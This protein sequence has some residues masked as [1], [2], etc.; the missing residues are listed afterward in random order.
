MATKHVVVLGH[1]PIGHSF[2][3]KLTESNAPFKISV[4]CE[5]PRPAYNRVML[6]QYFEDLDTNKHDQM[7][8]SYVTEEKLK[9]QDV[10]LIYGRATAV[11]RTARSVAYDAPGTGAKCSVQYDI[12]VMAT[13]SY[14]FV[15]PTPGMIIPEKRNLTWPDDPASRP[16]GVF[17]YRTIEDLES[18]SAAVKSGARKAAVIGGG[19]LGLEAAKAAY[20]LKLESHVLEMAPYLMPTQLNELGGTVLTDKIKDLGIQVHVGVQ[21]KEVVLGEDGKVTGIRILQ[22]GADEPIVLD[23]DMVIVSCGVRPRDELAKQCGLELGGRGGVKV[24]SSLRSSDENIYAIGEV[25]AIG[26]NLCY[27]L[28]APGV[29]QAGAL[30]KNLVDGPGSAEY[31]GSD[32]STKLKLLGCDVASF[33]RTLDFWF[34]RQFDGKDPGIKSLECKDEINGTYRRL[35]FTSDGSQLMGGILVGDA[36]DYSKLLQLSKKPD[37]AGNDPAGLLSGRPAAG[38]ASAASVDGGDGTGLADDDLICTCIGLT[39]ADVRTAIVEKDAHTVPL[40]K[41]ACKVGTGCGGCVTPVGE[42]PKLLANTLKK[43]G[44]AAAVGICPHFPYTRRE[45]F[46]IVKVKELKTMEEMLAAVGQGKSGCELCKPICASI[47]AGIWNEHC[48]KDGRDQLQDTNDRFLAN[49]Q[50]TGTYSII[51]RCAGGDIDPDTLM[52][53]ARTAKK[54]GL[55]TKITGAQRLGMF[56]AERHHLPAIYKELVDAGMESGQ[57][58][59]KA[60]RAVKSCVGT[61]WCRYGQQDSVNMAVILENRYKGIRSPHKLKMAV[62][63]CLRECAEAQGKDVGIIATQAGFNLYFGGNGG[64]KPVHAK[65]FATDLDEK[66]LLKYIDR[67]LMFYITTA[68]HL[69]RTAPWQAGLEGGIEFLRKV[70]IEDSLGICEDLDNL[71]EQNKKNWHCEWKAVAYEEELQKKFHQFVN[72]KETHDSEHVEYV[73]ARGQRHPNTYSPP[74]I[75][76][77]AL[78]SK[79]APSSDWEW[80]SA[81]KAS[82]YPRNGGLAV[83]HGSNELAVFHLPNHASELQWLA[84]QNIC[85]NK[86]ARTISRGLVGELASG[87]ITLADP[88]YKT[89]YDLRTG[90]GIANPNLNLSTF[91]TK[92]D[93]D[94]QVLVMV[95]PSEHM[96]KAFDEQIDKAYELAGMENKKAKAAPERK[97]PFNPADRKNLDW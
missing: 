3:E 7:K 27:G 70:V 85:P 13:G 2:I 74:D 94:G 26:G 62:S 57:A 18:I 90:T 47:L 19:L 91:E 32:L 63:G 4:V 68:K 42:V 56:G 44:K 6:T 35:C 1:G 67:Y 9:E 84:V 49:I 83:K 17:V 40:L 82:D 81:G 14:C 28:W 43:L 80:I 77:P 34:K 25:A 21:I 58:Y 92:V 72:T 66:T 38:A 65:L 36:K 16:A 54:Y 45:L 95:P 86:Q 30:V 20:D 51:P 87:V 88:I 60:L 69:E 50:K 8:L 12:L 73:D 48:L 71:M 78:Y 31:S 46:Q 33:G 93:A 76:G 79:D 11:D 97:G 15:P 10:Q 52:A 22:K 59:G 55:W 23:V 39:K 64:A 89:T 29:E 37:L 61:D 24:D 96:K 41:K 75:T 53:F 5:E